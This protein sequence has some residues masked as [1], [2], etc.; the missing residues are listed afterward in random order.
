MHSNH[1]DTRQRVTGA[2]TEGREGE[3]DSPKQ[4]EKAKNMV[5]S[6]FVPR[7]AGLDLINEG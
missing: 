7:K 3:G 5:N 6:H 2:M 1:C 4:V